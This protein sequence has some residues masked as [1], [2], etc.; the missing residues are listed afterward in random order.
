MRLHWVLVSLVG[1]DVL[2]LVSFVSEKLVDLFL[3]FNYALGY[4][5]LVLN[6]R[7]LAW[8]VQ[9]VEGRLWGRLP[10]G[11]FG[12]EIDCVVGLS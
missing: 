12:Q 7:G 4:Y 5:L 11:K 6:N 1:G 10:H 2:Q 8:L 9:V 3:V